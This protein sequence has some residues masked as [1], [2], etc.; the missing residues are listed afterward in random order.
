[1]TDCKN[2][3]EGASIMWEGPI[4]GPDDMPIMTYCL[5]TARFTFWFAG[6]PNFL[7]NGNDFQ[8]TISRFG[9]D[10]KNRLSNDNDFG[11]HRF[12][13][14]DSEQLRFRLE[15]FFLGPEEKVFFPYRSG[16]G[17]CLGVVFAKDWIKL[18]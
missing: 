3:Y 2:A 5:A 18:T 9:R 6:E 7:E 1:M 16:K 15:H 11:T 8:M 13:Q 17:R 12:S 4:R 14:A 10:S